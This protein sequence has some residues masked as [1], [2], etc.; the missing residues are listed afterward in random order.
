MLINKRYEK[1]AKVGQGAFGSV[2]KCID[3]KPGL[4]K[5]KR[6]E[7]E[8]LEEAKCAELEELK[9]NPDYDKFKNPKLLFSSEQE[10]ALG[11]LPHD[12]EN[13]NTANS[14]EAHTESPEEDKTEAES[15]PTYVALKKIKSILVT[16]TIIHLSSYLCIHSCM[17]IF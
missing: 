15:T 17:L 12:K 10:K 6:M 1:Q 16:L 14:T 5:Q 13:E 2:W 9:S 11:E 4:K 7:L 3:H 8:K